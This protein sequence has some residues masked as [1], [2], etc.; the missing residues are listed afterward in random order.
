MKLKV[1]TVATMLVILT[2]CT[3]DLTEAY[4]KY[5]CK[6]LGGVYRIFLGGGDFICN[7]GTRL[8]KTREPLPKGW[9][10]GGTE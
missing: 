10:V 2:G 3:S 8:K 6:D 9:R 5:Q 1:T 4:A 7:D